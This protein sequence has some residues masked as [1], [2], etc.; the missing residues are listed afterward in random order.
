[1]IVKEILLVVAKQGG[2]VRVAWHDRDDTVSAVVSD[3][4]SHGDLQASRILL[5]SLN[6]T[7]LETI[8]QSSITHKLGTPHGMKTGL[9]RQKQHKQ[10]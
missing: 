7:H 8:K 3:L 10:D 4:L 5:P 1:V 9:Q 2:V 6:N